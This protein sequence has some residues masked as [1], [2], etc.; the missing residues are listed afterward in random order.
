MNETRM[1]K[2]TMGEMEVPASAYYGAETERARRNFSI[3]RSA[4]PARVV[5]ALG[6]IKG[7]AAQVN[8]EL[9]GLDAERVGAIRQAADEVA[10]NELDGHFVVDVFQTGSG[11]SSNMNSNEVIANRASEI[12]GHALGSKH[13]HPNDH[14]NMGQSSNDVFPSAVQ[15]GAA[16]SL[17]EQL[18]PEME[19]LAD[20]VHDL[21][22]RTFGE[23][24]TGRTHLMDATPIRFGQ[25]FRG[26]AGQ[27]EK[28][29]GRIAAALNGLVELPLGGTTVGTGVNMLPGFAARV[30]ALLA[31]RTGLP[32][33]ETDNHFHAQACLDA[34]VHTSGVLRGFATSLYKIA[35]DVRWMASGPL[36]GLAELRIPAVQPGSSI[37]PAKVNPVICESVLMLCGQVMGNDH[38]VAFGNSQGQFELNTMM[39]IMARNT[40]ESVELLANGCAMFREKCL[41]EIEV[42]E[43]GGRIV[44][45]NPI[46]ATALNRA[47]G[48]EQAAAL[49]KESA[50]TGRT[51]RELAEE[52]TDL[53]QSQ[54]DDLLDPPRMC[55]DG[56]RH[57][58]PS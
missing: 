2:D 8:Q 58:R 14:V 53:S 26:F 23:V 47:I 6:L 18:L 28:G 38:A 4:V 40:V 19:R 43:A 32:V 25:V 20:C 35:N 45:H 5:Q 50:A 29:R 57:R 24:K 21:A 44:H 56:G 46:L 10:H 16:L 48:Y 12:L 7:A 31:D 49:A 27:V 33:R 39:P 30:C 34:V 22:D 15:L 42:T 3:S 9:G 37:M 55:G 36:C 17:H 11:T 13:V 54:L 1:E 41:E 52:R 51:V